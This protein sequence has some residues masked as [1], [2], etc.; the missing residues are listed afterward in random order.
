MRRSQLVSAVAM[1]AASVVALSACAGDTGDGGAGDAPKA[2][3]EIAMRACQPEN[4]LVPG[5]TNETCGGDV[6]DALFTGLVEYDP[7]T[8]EPQNAMAE[9]IETEDNKVFTVKLKPGWKFHDGTD[10][11]AKNF[12]DAWN[13]TAYGPNG[14]QNGYWFEQI[15][16][17]SDVQCADPE[18]GCK[19]GET[20]AK[21]LTGLEVVDDT[22]FTITT[23]QPFS[24]LPAKLGYTVFSPLPDSFFEDPEK[25]GRDPVGNGPFKFDSWKDNQEILVSKFADYAGEKK[26]NVDKVTFRHYQDMDA[27]Y[28]DLL[29]G[30]LDF[31]DQI[32]TAAQAGEKWKDDLGDR[33][34]QVEVGDR[35][36]V[37]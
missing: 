32:P 27:A 34:Q 36:S 30:N 22:T 3:G 31:H 14:L 25:F 13:Y 9:S 5:D 1:I 37:V 24:V 21:E 17:F 20:K 33:G 28:D 6:V 8:A 23:A 2:G 29:A 19:E 7:K 35:K 10:V 11:T 12:V 15:D 4:P 16:G 26:A 18:K